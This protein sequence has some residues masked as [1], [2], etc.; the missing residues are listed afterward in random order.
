[1]N[2]KSGYS[3]NIFLKFIAILL[4][5]ALFIGTIPVLGVDDV[6]SVSEDISPSSVGITPFNTFPMRGWVWVT[7]GDFDPLYTNL[8]INPT[9]FVVPSP[10]NAGFPTIPPNTTFWIYGLEYTPTGSPMYRVNWNGNIGYVWSADV[11]LSPPIPIQSVS[12]G[13]LPPNNRLNVGSQR[14]LTAIFNPT[15]ASWRD[16]TWTS[17]NSSIISVNQNGIIVAHGRGTATITLRSECGNRST[18]V[19]IEGFVPVS[20]VSIGNRPAGDTLNVGQTHTLTRTIAPN[21]ATN[22]NVTWTSLSPSVATINQ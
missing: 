16:V 11:V 7:R 9:P 22:T 8:I 2:I 4:V 3:N 21:N 14:G 13:D 12:I 10:G 17:S 18:S 15:N 19:V 20:G 5:L 6:A 1:M